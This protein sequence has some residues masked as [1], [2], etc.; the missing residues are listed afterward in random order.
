LS[1][2]SL[3]STSPYTFEHIFFFCL[4]IPFLPPPGGMK[5]ILQE[6]KMAYNLRVGGRKC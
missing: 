5:K 3:L 1:N 6:K 2:L 4:E